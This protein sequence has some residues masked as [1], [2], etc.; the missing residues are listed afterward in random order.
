[1]GAEEHEQ[2]L[3]VAELWLDQE[4]FILEA[5]LE[6]Y[7]PD[8][9]PLEINFSWNDGFDSQCKLFMY[10]WAKEQVR[11]VEGAYAPNAAHSLPTLLSTMDSNVSSGPLDHAGLESRKQPEPIRSLISYSPPQQSYA[12]ENYT[13]RFFQFL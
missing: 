9:I 1:M 13:T 11:I 7:V 12:E 8:S 3:S 5:A 6:S 10:W 4:I 2:S